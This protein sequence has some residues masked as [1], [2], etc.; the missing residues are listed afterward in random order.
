[1]NPKKP[2]AMMLGRFQ[3]F[4]KG[5]KELFK[6]ILKKHGQVAILIR[7]TG[8]IDKDNPY[9]A[10][11]VAENIISELAE[12][13]GKFEIV[14]VPNITNICYGRKVGYSFEKID[15]PD[16]IESISAT[17]IRNESSDNNNL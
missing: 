14:L 16:D 7:N 8:G 4:H 9:D 10:F 12:Y 15:L 13:S 5:H 11:S 2:T 1:M 17:K 3:P 6:A